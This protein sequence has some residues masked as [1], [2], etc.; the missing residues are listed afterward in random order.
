MTSTKGVAGVISVDTNRTCHPNGTINPRD[1]FGALATLVSPHTPG[2][3][4]S[5]DVHSYG[6]SW[7]IQY[8]H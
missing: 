7:L 3:S 4:F 2:A 8:T 1:Q 5:S 6:F